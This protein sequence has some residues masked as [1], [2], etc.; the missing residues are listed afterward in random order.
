MAVGSCNND[1]AGR[2]FF[3]VPESPVMSCP[4]RCSCCSL[5]PSVIFTLAGAEMA[6]GH[7]LCGAVLQASLD[8]GILQGG[9]CGSL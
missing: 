4:H 2:R 7:C 3:E 8:H 1:A 6:L 9:L 5:L